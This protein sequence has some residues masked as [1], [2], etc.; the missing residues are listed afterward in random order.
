M[1]NVDTYYKLFFVFVFFILIIVI[2]NSLGVIG[3]NRCEENKNIKCN[4][5]CEMRCK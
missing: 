4:C 5:C 1:Y 3:D 2:L